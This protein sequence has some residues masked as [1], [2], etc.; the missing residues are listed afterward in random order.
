MCGIVG[1]L[2]LDLSDLGIN[3]VLLKNV[4]D[5]IQHRGPDGEG[6]F[7]NGPIALIHRR[8]SIIDLSENGNQPFYSP[9]KR[10][11]I[12]FNGEI[13]N[14]IELR[15]ELEKLGEV[16]Y[17][18]SDTEVLLRL[19]IIYG[20]NC[21][22][23]LNGMFAFAIWDNANKKIFI[24]RDRIGI[25][26][27]YYSIYKNSLYFGSEPKALFAFGVPKKFDEDVLDELI[28]YKYVAGEN[29]CFKNIKRLLPGHSMEIQNGGITI[30]RWWN[31]PD[32]IMLNK[33]SIPKNPFEWFEE[34]FTSSVS[35]RTISD[36]PV[37]L[38]LSGG[39][40]SGS[41]AAAL[42]NN[43]ATKVS[44]FTVGFQEREYDE[45]RLAE[46]VCKKFGLN[47]NLVKISG[48]NL[49]ETII[50]ATIFHDEP[51]IHQN[52]AQMLALSRQA[53]SK[54]T[55]LLSGEGG[56]E[57]MGGY[58]RYKPLKYP[59]LLNIA[60]KITGLLKSLNNNQIV[61][62]F[63]KLN[64]YVSGNSLDEMVLL[65][66]SNI[67]PSDFKKIGISIEMDKFQYRFNII[68]EATK[69]YPKDAA[70]QAMYSDLFIHLASVLDRNDRM[71]MGAGIECRVPF[72]DYRLM[73][74]IPALPTNILL[75]GK[76][77]KKLLY[78]SIA[79][80]LPIEVLNFKKLGFSVPWESYM[81]SDLRFLKLTKD[82]Q[83]GSLDNYLG[84]FKPI[85]KL[86]MISGKS[87]FKKA[88]S[89]QLMMLEIWR[90]NY[91]EK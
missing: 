50:D 5:T 82:I 91:L 18:K 73:E 34:I 29:T 69:I 46:M 52:D 85:A 53:K 55:V 8:L 54:V 89:R 72:M 12:V 70:R 79:Q 37:G 1:I 7:V 43:G 42:Q 25:K 19:Y 77:G 35:Y 11:V 4:S 22:D 21:L 13:F 90:E 2:N 83:N 26:P 80:K 39:L 28:L 20:K 81:K 65:N 15:Q 44:A 74:M 62:R 23:K 71:T 63:D 68:K 27:L 86:D 88:I 78:D 59:N 36:V 38:M 75:K 10:F 58:V 48:E 9:D 66:A 17:T 41:I 24:A 30:F 45:S 51:L 56:D 40:D 49:Y 32:K 33:E 47:F 31:L 87:E 84:K 14:F 76:K 64:R 6:F 57:F 61:N 60:G 67:Y 16:F 3:N